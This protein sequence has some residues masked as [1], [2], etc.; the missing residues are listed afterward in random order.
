MSPKSLPATF[1]PVLGQSAHFRVSEDTDALEQQK[2]G[3]KPAV[4]NRYSSIRLVRQRVSAWSR[5]GA[6][7]LFDVI[8][9]VP[10]A[11][12]LIPLFLLI[13]IAVRLTSPGPVLF[14]QRRMGRGGRMF[15]IVKFRTTELC[16]NK[17]HRAATMANNQ[18]F[19]PVGSF[20][21]RWRL[22]KLPQL[23][24]VLRGDMSLVG[25]QPKPAEH[26]TERLQYRPGITGAATL[27]FA[28]EDS[29]LARLPKRDRDAYYCE[30]MLP[31]KHQLDL[32]YMA[33]ATFFS[34]FKLLVDTVLRRRDTS[35]MEEEVMS[36]TISVETSQGVQPT[37]TTHAHI[38]VI[39]GDVDVAPE[40]QF[41]EV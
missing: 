15:T 32:E 2:P 14:L 26:Q 3:R 27:A 23:W 24:N 4:T 21:C 17:A 39:P 10:V 28:Q 38:S 40:Q 1:D 35:L 41:T 33:R 20:L 25:P 13:G 16:E 18:R 11:P 6:K 8:C 5:S 7:R 22:D 12:F 9:I 34:D 19:T 31:A 29:F 36:E 37:M 30:R